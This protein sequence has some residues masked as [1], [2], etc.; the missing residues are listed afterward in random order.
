MNGQ[1]TN[2]DALEQAQW[3]GDYYASLPAWQ[4]TIL[5]LLKIKPPKNFPTA[6]TLRGVVTMTASAA[7]LQVGKRQIRICQCI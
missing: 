3:F 1:C 4:R 6:Q 7:G 5:R 2:P